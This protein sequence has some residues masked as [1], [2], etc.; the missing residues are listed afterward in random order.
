MHGHLNIMMLISP[1]NLPI[2][3]VVL[4]GY[5]VKRLV[6]APGHLFDCN[7]AQVRCIP[8]GSFGLS[9]FK[10]EQQKNMLGDKI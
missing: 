7:S 8:H 10:I 2:F 4:S 5:R 9:H 6:N 3:H 1:T